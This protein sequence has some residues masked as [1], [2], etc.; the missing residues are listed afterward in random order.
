SVLG[1]PPALVAA[2]VLMKPGD[3]R[4]KTNKRIER[5]L[6]FFMACGVVL[7][8]DIFFSKKTGI[9]YSPYGGSLWT[10]LI[11]IAK[12]PHLYIQKILWPS[13][14][15]ADYSY[16]PETSLFSL[17]V[18]LSV[19]VIILI[20]GAFVYF[21]KRDRA[22]AFF[23]AWSVFN[24]APVMNIIPTSKLIADRYAYLPS[25]GLFCLAGHLVVKW[26]AG[27]DEESRKSPALK[28]AAAILIIC[29]VA[30]SAY[31]SVRRNRIW[32]T[33]FSLWSAAMKVEPENP[34]VLHN[35][36]YAYFEQGD[37][38]TAE[39]LLLE[40]LKRD[41]NDV[42]AMVNLGAIEYELKGN[43]EKA[44]AYFEKAAEL[45][46]H[47]IQTWV[48]L[49]V[50]YLEQEEF[51]KA[52]AANWKAISLDRHNPDHR[53][54]RNILIKRAQEKGVRLNLPTLPPAPGR[55]KP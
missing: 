39:K 14:L 9:V 29:A 43:T 31:T 45:A 16:I 32:R 47:R 30:G 48:N 51:E 2:E 15:C 50:V 18:L 49:F 25:I 3:G 5:I 21:A 55:R 20:A 26:A 53:L 40:A 34:I 23:I 7:A 10:H 11:T 42:P 24:L 8:A 28:A 37:P 33:D 46:P 52:A 1:F 6:P 41:P 36:G 35:M 54:R 17:S 22:A 4:E 19:A 13:N 44:L 27:G 38:V 12:I